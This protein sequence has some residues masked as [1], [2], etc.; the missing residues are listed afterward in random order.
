MWEDTKKEIKDCDIAF[1]CLPHG[2]TQEIISDL[3]SDTQSKVRVVDL[4]ADF[5]LKDVST[6]A[7]WYGKPHAA[8]DLQKEAVYGLP[9]VR[10]KREK[11][12]ECRLLANPGCYPTAAQLPLIPLL[13]ADLIESTDIIIDAKSGTTGRGARLRRPFCIVR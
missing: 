12:K 8:A 9:E 10:G 7:T 1:C 11:I 4:S 5:R 13:Q 6:Y 2:T 3:C